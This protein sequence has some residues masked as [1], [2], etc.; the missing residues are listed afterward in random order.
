M[1]TAI[2][3]DFL[4]KNKD[5][6]NTGKVIPDYKVSMGSVKLDVH[7]EGG[8]GSGIHR[9]VGASEGGKTSEALV[10]AKNA[11]ETIPNAKLL[12]V[13]AEG[14][15]ADNVKKRSGIKWVEDDKDWES[16]T[17]FVLNLNIFEPMAD[18]IDNL[19]KANRKASKK[20]R[21]TY[22]IVID[23]M[24]GLVLKEDADKDFEGENRK[25][26]G[27]PL[28][29]K[30]LFARLSLPIHVEK[31]MM[32]VMSQKSSHI[33]A[34]YEKLDQLK[35]GASGGNAAIHFCDYIFTFLPKAG[36]KHYLAKEGQKVDLNAD[37]FNVIGHIARIEVSK[38]E[39]ET[40]GM[41][42]EYPVL[43]GKR[44]KDGREAGRIWTEREVFD[45]MRAM[46]FVENKGAWYSYTE[47]AQEVLKSSKFSEDID[48][49]HQGA[50]KMF[51]YFSEGRGERLDFW[52]QYIVNLLL[53]DDLF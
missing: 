27:V 47:S 40:T 26:A 17:G 6:Y 8:L 38:S 15:L 23:S 39:N 18:L 4:K 24:D 19:I 32:L 2:L 48:A 11:L 16:G 28:L 7:L 1:S 41:I 22:I 35:L 13:K 25:V 44:G 43:H 31:H 34:Q 5:H 53:S 52:Y 3:G 33:P 45:L 50:S 36:K 51:E 37:K 49:K 9:F 20:D 29:T 46:R 12:F 21:I 14:R 10:V 42:I 30:Q